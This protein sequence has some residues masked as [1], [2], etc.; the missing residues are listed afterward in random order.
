MRLENLKPK[1]LGSKQVARIWCTARKGIDHRNL[2]LFVRWYKLQ[3]R[4]GYNR[5][6]RISD[7]VI[8]IRVN[9][10]VLRGLRHR[11]VSYNVSAKLI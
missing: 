4:A 9:V 1:A 5:L 10:Q 11:L 2:F 7:W 8:D 6:M 3:A